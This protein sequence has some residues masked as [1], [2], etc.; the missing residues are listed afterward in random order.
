MVIKKNYLLG[1]KS[2][3]SWCEE[4]GYS[5]SEYKRIVYLMHNKCFTDPEEAHN[6]HRR[7]IKG[8][9]QQRKLHRLLQVR[10]NVRRFNGWSDEELN[11]SLEE[12]KE[13]GA[14]KRARWVK[15]GMSLRKYCRVHN[16]PYNTIRDRIVK[17][18]MSVTQA[19]DY[20]IEPRKTIY[21]DGK[22]LGSIVGR[23]KAKAIYDRIA[24]GWD[25]SKA[26]KQPID[27]FYK[28]RKRT[29]QEKDKM[30][31]SLGYKSFCEKHRK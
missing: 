16:L 9:L 4:R 15:D 24:R 30:F 25:I 8:N 27:S 11:I 10:R 3:R 17:Q 5:Q 12:A 6:Y 7:R 20:P 14:L 19:V 29:E 21:I 18:N 26:I 28:Y 2:L 31:R 13:K 23:K 22:P 1:D